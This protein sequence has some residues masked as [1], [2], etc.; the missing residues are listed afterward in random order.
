[1]YLF[2]YFVFIVVLVPRNALVVNAN[3]V[4]YT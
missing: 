2:V 1:M 3:R 4:Q